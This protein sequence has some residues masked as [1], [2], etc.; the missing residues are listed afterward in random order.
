MQLNEP[1]PGGFLVSE[2]WNLMH[3]KNLTKRIPPKNKPRSRPLPK[4]SEKYLQAYER[5]K[6][7]LDQMEMKIEEYFHFKST[8]HCLFDLHL[9]EYRVLI[10]LA[11]IN[12]G[13]AKAWL[14]A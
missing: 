9:I 8:K 5:L 2:I 11:D 6:E 14:K 12:M 13:R 1:P 7:I 3:I 10:E 4:A